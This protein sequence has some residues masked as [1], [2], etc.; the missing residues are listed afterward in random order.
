LGLSF[1]EL[2]GGGLLVG[3]GIFFG[4]LFGGL[5]YTNKLLRIL[6]RDWSSE[7]REYCLECML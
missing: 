2:A 7:I 5:Y 4:T 1:S 3:G 6:F